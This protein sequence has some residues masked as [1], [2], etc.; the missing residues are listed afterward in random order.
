MDHAS[1]IPDGNRA[2]WL[3]VLGLLLFA[4]CIGWAIA[5]FVIAL[6]DLAVHPRSPGA[7]FWV[8]NS[9]IAAVP[10]LLPFALVYIDRRR[11]ARPSSEKQA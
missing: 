8:E 9:L 10:F 11:Q 6:Y 5:V 4:P 1:Q 7:W 2:G 3:T